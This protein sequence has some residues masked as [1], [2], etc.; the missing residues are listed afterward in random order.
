[1]NVQGGNIGAD[2]GGH[3]FRHA[4]MTLGIGLGYNTIYATGSNADQDLGLKARGAGKVRVAGDAVVNGKLS[5]N[6]NALNFSNAEWDKNHNIYNNVWDLDKEGAW[7]G[8]KINSYQGLRVRVGDSNSSPPTT[9]LEVT[10]S[11]TTFK[12]V[13]CINKTCIT[14]NDLKQ[15]QNGNIK[16]NSVSLGNRWIISDEGPA[17]VFRDRLTGGDKRFALYQGRYRDWV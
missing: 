8:M 5:L 2:A 6:R 4:N 7:D 16:T 1:M 17:L 11:S 10:D 13:L 9:A 14:E 15:I 3:E 12:D